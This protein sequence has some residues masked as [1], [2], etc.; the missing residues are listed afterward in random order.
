MLSV[1]P[2]LRGSKDLRV[3]RKM[4]TFQLFFQ[5]GRAKDL[6][7]PLYRF[8]F[9]KAAFPLRRIFG[10]TKDEVTGEWRKIHNEELNELYSSPNIVLVIKSMRMRWAGYVARMWERGGILMGKPEGKNHLGDP[11]VDARI[12]LRWIF[13]KSDVGVWNGSS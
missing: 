9:S 6:S 12:I 13:R 2:G 11:G 3:G 5:S 10:T 4:A 1:Q 8:Y 7:A